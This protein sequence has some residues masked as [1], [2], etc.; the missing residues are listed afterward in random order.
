[1]NIPHQQKFRI[2]IF[3]AAALV[4]CL[5]IALA[6][7]VYFLPAKVTIF[8]ISNNPTYQISEDSLNLVSELSED[9]TIYWL[10]TNGQADESMGNFLLAYFEDE[11]PLR[12]KIVDTTKN[13]DFSKRYTTAKLNNYSLIVESARRYQV[14]EVT[15]MYYYTNEY[16]NYMAGATYKIPQ[17]QYDA[18][19]AAYGTYMDQAETRLFF[20]GEALL[21]SAIDYVTVE[22]IP[23]TYILSGH[24]DGVTSDSLKNI[25]ASAG[26]A[27]EALYLESA[28]HLP[29][30]AGC[31][32]LFSPETDLSS[33]E[34]DLLKTHVN[35]GGSFLLVAGPNTSDFKNL[36]SVTD[37]FGMGPTAGIVLD[38]NSQ[39]YKADPSYLLPLINSNHA[40]MYAIGSMGYLA[41]MP[42]SMGIAIDQKP[43][44]NVTVT[45][46]LGT[47]DKGYRASKDSARTPLCTPSAQIVA[48]SAILKTT[49]VEG[50]VNNAY[51]AWFA[52]DVAF[53]DEALQ[54][55][56]YG[57]YF[58]L[59]K[60]VQW[61][62][63]EDKFISAY[64]TLAAD[65]L[66]LPT[67][68]KMTNTASVLL[69]LVAVVILPLG[70][71][72]AGVIIWLKRRSR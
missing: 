13:P 69:G 18:M 54:N 9:V 46:L 29:E 16:I 7:T 68:D 30:D 43:P 23:R 39:Y 10:C 27:P 26:V 71:L 21:T 24:G 65:D 5:L 40:A 66:S 31:I 62:T 28:N 6:V 1:M 35:A 50:T 60:T 11:T 70:L 3:V 67:L 64:E 72:S 4:L 63:E 17:A 38:A 55:T 45:A 2:K 19:Y 42:E 49:T 37:L 14:I 48:A 12:L 57:N 20:N 15:D 53:T 51:F 36:A 32:I 34:A 52:S 33:H 22:H 58:Y 44:Q 59:A 8:D 25:M 47:S 41:F 56:S 61:M